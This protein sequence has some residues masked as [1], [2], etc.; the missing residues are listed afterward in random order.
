MLGGELAD[1]EPVMPV[2][3]DLG[4]NITR[5]G[6]V[7][8]GQTT[9]VLIKRSSALPF[10]CWRGRLRRPRQ[11]GS[12]LRYCRA[13]WPATLLTA[14]CYGVALH[15][16]MPRVRS[17][18][19]QGTTDEQGHAGSGCLRRRPGRRAPARHIGRPTL[20]LICRAG[21]RYGRDLLHH[22]HVSLRCNPR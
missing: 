13:A 20:C 1:V 16:C 4:G 19:R 8:F 15:A 9:K 21:K 6:P 14:N 17:T 3:R 5:F 7:K 18:D 22:S 12:T 11:P 2:L 10:P